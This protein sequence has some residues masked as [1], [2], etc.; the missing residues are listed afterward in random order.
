MSTSDINRMNKTGKTALCYL[1]ISLFCILFGAV[2]ELFSHGVYS[3]FMLYA[4]VIPLVGGT[5]PFFSMALSRAPIP[6]RV[7]LNLYHSGIAAL[8]IG[9][10][11]QGALEIYGTTNRLVSV[12]WVL[13]TLFPAMAVFTDRLLQ[14]RHRCRKKERG[15]LDL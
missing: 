14:Q 7:S 10:L 11:F 8:T 3:Y 15:D 2:Y 9:C 4:F 1:F 5:L 12:Y 6:N 13:G